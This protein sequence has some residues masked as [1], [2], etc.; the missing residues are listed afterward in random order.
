MRK[1][2]GISKMCGDGNWR[3][4]WIGAEVSS[5]VL[6]YCLRYWTSMKSADDIVTRKHFST[7]GDITALQSLEKRN[8]ELVEGSAILEMRQYAQE[9]LENSNPEDRG[10]SE[11]LPF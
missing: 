11:E 6:D 8:E 7:D 3:Y 4:E 1:K 5:E 2:F 10:K 9:L